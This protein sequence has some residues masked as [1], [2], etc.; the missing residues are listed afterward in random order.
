MKIA[1]LDERIERDIEA[2]Q[3]EVIDLIRALCAIPAP[4]HDEGKRA[5][6]IK[7]WFDGHGLEARVDEAK[8]VLCPIGLEEYEDMVVVMA[9]TDTVFPDRTP[10]PMKEE[11]GRLYCPGVGDDTT[12]LAAMMM[13][14]AYIG[15]RKF[16]PRCG[17]LFVANACEEGL[18]NL[19]GCKAI[20]K[21][22]GS[23][24][25]AFLSLDCDSRNV[26]ARAVGSTR[27]EIT[28]NTRGG[29]SFADF[30]VRSA[31]AVLSEL[32]CALYRQPV[33]QMG[34]SITTYN[35]GVMEGG[36]SVN[37]IA[38]HARM[39]YEYR[40]DHAQCLEEMERQMQDIL[41]KNTWPDARVEV[42][43]LGLRPCG[44]NVDPHMQ[45]ELEAACCEALRRYAGERPEVVSGSTDCNI[46]LSMGIPSAC[47]GVY[48]GEGEHTREEWVELSSIGSGM[49]AAASVLLGWFEEKHE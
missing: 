24:V 1:L 39:L 31:I 32:T 47:F 5:A 44:K 16:I 46:P 14:A 8:N 21:A 48:H 41:A 2:M 13:L 22:F 23:R 45:Q 30:G 25:K 27:Y 12:N 7:A 29:H 43:L 33:P 4:S 19:E 6:F 35:V 37:S 11:N 18:G 15:K 40:S 17:V 3:P 42:K 34:N 9:H 28:A 49:K 10:M 36:T 38:Q 20:M 26:C